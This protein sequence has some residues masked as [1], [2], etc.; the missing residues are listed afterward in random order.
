MVIIVIIII[1]VIVIHNQP[2]GLPS[3]YHTFGTSTVGVSIATENGHTAN[4]PAAG[5]PSYTFNNPKNHE[6]WA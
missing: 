4:I 3:M 5:G 1:V 6:R 2:V